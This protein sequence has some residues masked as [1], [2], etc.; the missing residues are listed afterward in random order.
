[1]NPD[2]GEP[3]R[4]RVL[5]VDQHADAAD[6]LAV[7][8]RNMGYQV[9]VA[10]EADAGLEMFRAAL[11]QVVLLDV[12]MTN[13]GQAVARQMR[14]LLGPTVKLCAMSG[15]GPSADVT[16]SEREVLDYYLVE[17]VDPD[18]LRAIVG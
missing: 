11:P 12:H 14:Q 4:K 10:N 17:P 7:V 5:I 18:T 6:K 9:L 3:G 1:M 13:N 16:Q 15:N 2:P 8:L